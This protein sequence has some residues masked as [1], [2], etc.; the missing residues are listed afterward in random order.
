MDLAAKLTLRLEEN[1]LPHARPLQL[2]A[3]AGGPP[4]ASRRGE[5]SLAR[6]GRLNKNGCGL[7]QAC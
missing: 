3:H 2:H 6:A 4:S 5:G 1:P 7:A